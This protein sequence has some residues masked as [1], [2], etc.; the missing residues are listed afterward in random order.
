MENSAVLKSNFYKIQSIDYFM[1]NKIGIFGGFIFGVIVGLLLIFI[2]SII[3]PGEDL[4]GI[5]IITLL[6]SGLLFAFIG[7]L[8]KKKSPQLC[9]DW[10]KTI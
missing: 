9:C 5:V 2:L 3:Y 7:Y 10:V 6:L 8:I 1:K 4:A